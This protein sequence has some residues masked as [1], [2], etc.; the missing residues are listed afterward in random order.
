MA[1]ILL[2]ID[3]IRA[4]MPGG[5]VPS[6]TLNGLTIAMELGMFIGVLGMVPRILRSL[7]EGAPRGGWIFLLV[8]AAIS[9]LGIFGIR[10][11]GGP[12]VEFAPRTSS[13]S[14]AAEGLPH[15]MHEELVSLNKL[16]TKMVSTQWFQI[17]TTQE[18]VKVR[19]LTRQ[20]LQ[21]A[22]PLCRELRE[23]ADRILKVFADATAKGVAHSTLS[24]EPAATR[25]ETWQAT[26]EVYGF[27]DE[28]LGLIEQHWDEWL[29]N[30]FP[31][32]KSGLK[33]WQLEIQR[34]IA[35]AGVASR[36]VHALLNGAVPSSVVG[37]DAATLSKQLQEYVDRLPKLIER[38]TAARW[39]RLR[40][41]PATAATRTRQDLQ[42]AREIYSQLHECAQGGGKVVAQAESK[43]VDLTVFQT[44]KALTRLQFWNPLEQAYQ[45]SVEQL[46]LID[47]HWDEWKLQP[48]APDEKS[49][50]PWQREM[51]RL[52]DVL[53]TKLK[54]A[55][56]ASGAAV[57]T[58]SPSPT[59]ALAE[60]TGLA[61]ELRESIASWHTSM[62]KYTAIRWAKIDFEDPAQKKT[63]TRRDFEEAVALSREAAGF[64]ER[65][66]KLLAQ[67]K[68]Q[69]ID[70]SPA[71]TDAL[72]L[73]PEF[74]R[75]MQDI[76]ALRL[77]YRKLVDQHWDEWLTIPE[78]SEGKP[79]LWQ[80]EMKRLWD[81]MDAIHKQIT[82][83]ADNKIATAPPVPA[84]TPPPPPRAPSPPGNNFDQ[85]AL[86][87]QM[88]P[89]V[90]DYVAAL[91]RV[92]GTRWVK[93]PDAN[94]YHPQKITQTDLHDA[95]DKLREL[96][97]AIDKLRSA[98]DAQ[99]LSVPA[100]EKEYWRIK[101]ETSS[102]FQQLTKLLEDNWKEWHTS[103]IQPKSGE[104]KPW[105]KEALRLQGEID[106][107]KQIDQTSILL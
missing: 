61:K 1:T 83:M 43:G 5:E 25:P 57:T 55:K 74:W 101:R 8:V 49:M 15:Q 62:E 26:R 91:K 65:I 44:E 37:N 77:K 84:T 52:A 18:P 63:L 51:K 45:A 94:S 40:E 89:A 102:A 11:L 14:T 9:G 19:T 93:S 13:T 58:S 29:A 107:L 78:K 56:A 2:V 7:P 30:P 92:Q 23:G 27:T 20:D 88:L 10:L 36:Q 54:E 69:R 35:A 34:L 85:L 28:Y 70:V 21:E 104:V 64:Q 38:M 75:A 99:T 103:G 79:N 3:F 71:T 46:A 66:L 4:L 33:P 86:Q 80:R 17:F 48:E 60:V 68:S 41:N 32:E 106:K 73:R 24:D 98:L 59:P 96:I 95:N 72:A 105:Q 87:T 67:A 81:A 6:A 82:A 53:D 97:E 50:K 47:Q 42:E 90:G 16:S 22:R 100:A 31:V 39:I 12:S 76:N